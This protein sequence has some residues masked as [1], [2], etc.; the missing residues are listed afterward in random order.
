M[1]VILIPDTSGSMSD[2]ARRQ[3]LQDQIARLKASGMAILEGR[4]LAG[5]GVS[6]AKHPDSLLFEVERALQAHQEADT[7]YAFSDF[8]VT[9]SHYWQSD[10]EGYEQLG[11][12]LSDRRVRLYIGTVKYQPPGELLKIARESGGGLIPCAASSGLNCED[13]PG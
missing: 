3:T 9:G 13:R 12:I 8:E 11:K 6:K 10:A 4:G 7:I 5:F 2:P 1:H